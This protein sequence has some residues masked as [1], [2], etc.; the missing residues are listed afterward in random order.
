MKLYKFIPFYEFNGDT[1]YI[2]SA[3]FILYTVEL[4]LFVMTHDGTVA[5]TNNQIDK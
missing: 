4:R 2:F 1:W 3:T 5:L